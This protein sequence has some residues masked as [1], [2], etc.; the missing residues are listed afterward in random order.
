MSKVIES[1]THTKQYG[2]IHTQP[3]SFVVEQLLTS[4]KHWQAEIEG[5]FVKSGW[6]DIYVQNEIYHLKEGQV[7]C[8]PEGVVHSFLKKSDHGVIYVIKFL[9]EHI[10][11]HCFANNTKALISNLYKNY[12]I[13]DC[14]PEMKEI[15]IQ[16]TNNSFGEYNECYLCAKLTELT[17]YFLIKPDLVGMKKKNQNQD[18]SS[19]LRLAFEFIHK[20][21]R[22][23][24]SLKVLAS[25]LGFSE[26]Y[27][28]RYIKKKTG[29]T[30]VE[31]VNATR[32]AEAET[33][34]LE[35]NDNITEIAYT[36]GFSSVQT[37][38]RVF[39]QIRNI[40]PT[41]YRKMR[42]GKI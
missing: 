29:M 26:C 40:N 32:I 10:L 2:D 37:F 28:S 18:A 5:V 21:I 36:I 6:L 27:C 9:Q 34:L 25:Y 19:S 41:E 12:F 35:T 14:L 16:C 38:N 42:K 15:L 30:F 3:Y 13:A 11:K 17:T 20:H 24:I 33:L 8:I 7:M 23:E 22:D 39:K 31:Y 4:P 1:G